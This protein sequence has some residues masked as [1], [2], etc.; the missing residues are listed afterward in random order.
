MNTITTSTSSCPSP[1]SSFSL[2]SC[3]GFLTTSICSRGAQTAI[4]WEWGLILGASIVFVVASEIY[5]ACFRA[6][7][8]G[9]PRRP[10]G[11][12][13]EETAAIAEAARRNVVVNAGGVELVIHR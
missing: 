1:S 9:E 7:L 3:P 10:T 2:L 6:W 5:K 11:H 8:T 12:A 13:E 4:S